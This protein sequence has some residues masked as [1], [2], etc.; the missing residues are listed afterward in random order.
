MPGVT[1]SSGAV[2]LTIHRP[3]LPRLHDFT[4]HAAQMLRRVTQAILSFSCFQPCPDEFVAV[5]DSYLG[6][7]HGMTLGLGELPTPFITSR[8]RLCAQPFRRLCLFFIVMSFDAVE[9]CACSQ[10][11]FARPGLMRSAP[12]PAAFGGGFIAPAVASI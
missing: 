6:A 9:A 11:A 2:S 8:Y 5:R 4:P 3:I 1:A 7:A 12:Q 10:S